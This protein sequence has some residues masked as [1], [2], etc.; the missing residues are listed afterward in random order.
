MEPIAWLILVALALIGTPG[1]V[2]IAWRT[3]FR[4]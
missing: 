4:R 1:T 2:I 3:F